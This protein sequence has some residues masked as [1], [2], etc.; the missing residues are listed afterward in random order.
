[1]AKYRSLGS[2]KRD[3][4]R[5]NFKWRILIRR[6]DLLLGC[7]DDGETYAKLGEI[8]PDGWD[9]HKDKV[10]VLDSW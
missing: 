3:L 2:P 5:A 4:G 7:A 9:D 1:M 6:K 8:V 10:A